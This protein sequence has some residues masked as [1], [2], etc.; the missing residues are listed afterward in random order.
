MLEPFFFKQPIYHI[1]TQLHIPT[2][3]RCHKATYTTLSHSNTFLYINVY[4]V[5]TQLH[6][7]RCH[8]TS[9]CHTVIHTLLSHSYTYYGTTH[10]Y[11]Y[12]VAT[13]ATTHYAIAN[14]H[15]PGSATRPQVT[16]FMTV[17]WIIYV[18]NTSNTLQLLPDFILSG[19]YSINSVKVEKS[20]V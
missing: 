11:T 20:N 6:I 12:N 7:P 14:I 16:Q 4:S 19:K 5:I 18:S 17:K 10:S 15:L 3:T 9:H 13:H 2:H 1:A 8:T